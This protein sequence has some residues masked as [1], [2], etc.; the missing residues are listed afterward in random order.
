VQNAPALD[1]TSIES[2]GI[3]LVDKKEKALA[4]LGWFVGHWGGLTPPRFQNGLHVVNP[5]TPSCIL[6]QLTLISLAFLP[7]LGGAVRHAWMQH[8][9]SWLRAPSR[10]C[11]RRRFRSPPRI[12]T[13][14]D[15]PAGGG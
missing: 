15:S 1:A 5:A 13:P 8:A 14:G 9:G 12:C 6:L 2:V 7:W 11:W 4:L 10:V 3:T